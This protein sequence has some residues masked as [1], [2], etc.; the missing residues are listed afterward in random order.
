MFK[1]S[2]HH[3]ASTALIVSLISCTPASKPKDDRKFDLPQKV[4]PTMELEN[5]C[6]T[7]YQKNARG[8]RLSWKGSVPVVFQLDASVPNDYVPAIEEAFNKW[9]EVAGL[10]LV[11]L[12]GYRG[13]SSLPGADLRNTIYFFSKNSSEQAR[14]S[15]KTIFNRDGGVAVTEVHY[16]GNR[17]YDTDI[18]LN[19]I[20]NN[21]S[22]SRA[23][24]NAMDVTT[25]VLHEIG[26][27][28]GQNHN[29]NPLSI[30]FPT[31]SSVGIALRFVDRE[32][33]DMLTCEY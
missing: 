11:R 15:A 27:A 17:I 25:V 32:S 8:K 29:D 4:M 1:A 19:G 22:T 16:L 2:L 3:F 31:A 33:A 30:M 5:K 9:N 14:I 28:L 24:L 13:D 20:N 21:F 7:L 26:H 12:N 23:R 10:T 18:I 6:N